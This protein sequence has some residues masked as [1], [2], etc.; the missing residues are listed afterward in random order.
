MNSKLAEADRADEQ[1]WM[2]ELSQ[3]VNPDE[4]HFEQCRDRASWSVHQTP[5][6]IV[7]ESREIIIPQNEDPR[8]SQDQFDANLFF[9][10]VV[11][12]FSHLDE[13]FRVGWTAQT[14]VS[15]A[16]FWV[17]GFLFKEFGLMMYRA[18]NLM[19]V[20][21]RRMLDFDQFDFFGQLAEIV[22]GRSRTKGVFSFSSFSDYSCFLLVY[23]FLFLVLS[24]LHLRFP[25]FDPKPKTPNPKP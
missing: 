17:N 15:C 6:I 9:H 25:V 23:L 2:C 24:L 7:Q 12:G 16:V 13:R 18:A 4:R 3:D 11:L 14:T 5:K 19:I 10:I 22:I 20:V 1:Q 8:T 21:V